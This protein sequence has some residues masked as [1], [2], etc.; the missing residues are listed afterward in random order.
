MTEKPTSDESLTESFRRLGKN[1]R[2]LAE[3]AWNSEERQKFTREIEESIS[4]IGAALDNAAHDVVEHP[5]IQRLREEI[6]E[7]SERLRSGEFAAELKQEVQDAI[8]EINTR[9]ENFHFESSE[10]VEV[11]PAGGDETE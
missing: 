8:D 9:V 3:D 4:E 1:L 11:P 5:E 10:E 6:N 2:N 7:F